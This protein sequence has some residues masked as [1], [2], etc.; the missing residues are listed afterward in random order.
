[1]ISM[2]YIWDIYGIYY[3]VPRRRHCLA[4]GEGSK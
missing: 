3:A 1:L 4:T 2:G